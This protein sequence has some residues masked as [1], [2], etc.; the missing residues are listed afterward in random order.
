MY[1]VLELIFFQEKTFAAPEHGP[2]ATKESR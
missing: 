1:S 2:E